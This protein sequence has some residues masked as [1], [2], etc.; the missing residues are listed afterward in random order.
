[1]KN[2]TVIHV[3]QPIKT[4]RYYPLGTVRAIKTSAASTIRHL[5]KRWQPIERLR[6]IVRGLNA[7]KLHRGIPDLLK[8]FTIFSS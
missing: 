3:H 8:R 2:K 6:I 1:M 7:S 5:E 4:A